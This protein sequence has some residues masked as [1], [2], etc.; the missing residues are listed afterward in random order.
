[1]DSNSLNDRSSRRNI[2]TITLQE[3]LDLDAILRKHNHGK[4]RINRKEIMDKIHQL[5]EK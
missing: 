5:V 1:M 4:N 2:K 3:Y